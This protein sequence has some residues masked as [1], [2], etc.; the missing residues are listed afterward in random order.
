MKVIWSVAGLLLGVLALA[1]VASADEASAAQVPGVKGEDLEPSVEWDF[2]RGTQ[3]FTAVNGVAPL[4]VQDGALQI[5]V[6]GFDPYIHA[7]RVNLVGERDR[8]IE[9]RLRAT[10]GRQIKIY[11][12]TPTGGWSESRSLAFDIVAD[13][14]YRD[15]LVDLWESPG[16]TGPIT[17]FRLDLEPPESQGAVV[18]IERIRFYSLGPKIDLVDV[19]FNR[20]IV[21]P[22]E[23]VELFATVRNT[24]GRIIQGLNWRLVSP[25]GV[26]VEGAGQGDLG[27]LGLG[28]RVALSWKLRAEKAGSYRLRLEASSATLGERSFSIPLVVTEPL[29]A[30]AAPGHGQGAGIVAGGIGE[31]NRHVVLEREGRR[32]V[33]SRSGEGYGAGI[34]Y[35]QVDGEWRP[36][37]AL[38]APAVVIAH[39]AGRDHIALTPARA[40]VTAEAESAPG[41]VFEGEVVDALSTRWRFRSVYRWGG[42]ADRTEAYRQ[43]AD[44]IEVAHEVTPDRP[45]ELLLFEGLTLLVG[46]GSSGGA[47]ESAIFPGLEW[48]TAQER[49]SST[50]DAHPPINLRAAPHPLKVTVPHMAVVTEGHLVGLMWDPLQEWAR[51]AAMPTA[52]FASPNWLHG[53][54]NHLLALTAPSA[55]EWVRENEWLAHTPYPVAAGETIRLSG[56]VTVARTGDVLAAIDLYLERYGLPDPG[57]PPRTW[58]EQRRLMAHAYMESYWRPQAKGWG[59]VDGWEPQ[60]FPAHTEVLRMLADREPDPALRRAMLARVEEVVLA[61]ALQHGPGWLGTSAGGHIAL[62]LLPYYEGYLTQAIDAWRRDVQDK[63]NRQRPDGH[64]V[65]QPSNDSQRVLGTPGEKA[66]GLTATPAWDVLRFAR[67]TGDRRAREAGLHALEAMREFRIPRAAQTWEVPVHSPDILAAGIAVGAYIEG[68]RLTGDPAYLEDAR[69]WARAGL[70]FVYLWGTYDRPVMKYATIPV[71]GATH[72]VLPWFGRP[73]QW[74]GLVYAYHVADLA[75]LDPSFPW[76]RIAR[77]IVISAMRQE[78][79]E[80]PAKGGFPDVW[81]LIPNR[82]IL[83]VDINPE[84][85]AKPAFYVFEGKSPDIKTHVVQAGEGELRINAVADVASVEWSPVRLAFSAEYAPGAT[86]YV[87][88]TGVDRP[89]EVRVDG[90]PVEE[91]AALR[92]MQAE[93]GWTY[94]RSIAGSELVIKI[95]HAGRSQVEVKLPEA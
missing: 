93:S 59:H 26:T 95:L 8:Y 48:L 9:L 61:A 30:D 75:S 79:T 20:G 19:R 35:A 78:R 28:Q 51:G 72:Y 94:R 82:P 52:R 15:Y 29:P 37:A 57:D 63:I 5:R 21:R 80:E 81:E 67:V 40:T 4:R 46:E 23:W 85:I 60:P 6:T 10:S 13:G 91:T 22:G 14:E 1:A 27:D 24:G 55:G 32:L 36:V 12:T 71:F 17:Q 42:P 47:K 18:D 56:Q 43:K 62:R 38:P 92:L 86:T 33:F 3:G 77:G 11:Y 76:D 88:I 69:Y 90:T 53:Q 83:N 25:D 74:N 66:L 87:L 7:P 64:W 68:Y 45:S 39:P 41:V 16:W 65:F 73:V 34:L 58:E 2:S 84:T 44:W 49:S 70:P 50:L 89:A 31:E 54:E